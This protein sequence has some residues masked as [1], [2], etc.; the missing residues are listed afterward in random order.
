[1]TRRLST[2]LREHGV[3]GRPA[4]K[5]AAELTSITRALAAGSIGKGAARRRVK[6]LA[7]QGGLA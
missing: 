4:S 1:M 5:L 3:T 7:Q 2:A 6:K